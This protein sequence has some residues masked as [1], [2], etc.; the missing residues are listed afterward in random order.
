MDKVALLVMSEDCMGCHACEVACKQEHGLEVGPRLMKV[1]ERA[2]LFLP[3][4]C[5]HCSR[6]PCQAACP[7]GAISRNELGI[8]LIDEEACIGCLACVE[9]CPFGAAQFD[10]GRKVAVKCDL[11]QGRL[12]KGEEP[13]CVR[14]CPTR[15]IVWGG[16][17]S[18]SE[19]VTGRVLAKQLKP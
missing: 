12:A 14:A 9:A 10:E 3:I 13:A 5:H 7:V 2:P 18:I 19:A 17:E 4:Y 15:C 16:A 8:V 6:P 1:V 11:C